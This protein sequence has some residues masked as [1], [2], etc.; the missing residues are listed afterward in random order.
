MIPVPI[1]NSSVK[2]EIPVTNK[3]V[4]VTRPVTS[5]VPRTS[6]SDR[7]IVVP[8]PTRL[9]LTIRSSTST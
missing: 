6:K 8:I 9:P 2:V 4:V 1:R 5:T 3:L 7:G